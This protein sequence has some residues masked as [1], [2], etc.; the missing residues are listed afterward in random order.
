MAYLIIVAYV[1]LRE[2]PRHPFDVEF[3]VRLPG[4][5][6]EIPHEHIAE[7]NVVDLHEK[8]ASRCLGLQSYLPFPLAVA[9]RRIDD[10]A[11]SHGYLLSG[12]TPSPDFHRGIALNHHLVGDHAWKRDFSFG[13]CW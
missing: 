2:K 6:P 3:L 7:R 13:A 10:I 9:L 12:I 5:E 1:H 8:R 4:H 11:E